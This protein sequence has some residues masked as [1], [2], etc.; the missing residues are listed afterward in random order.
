MPDTIILNIPLKTY[1]KKYLTNKYGEIHSVNKSSWLGRYLIVLLDKHY[2]KS[3]TPLTIDDYYPVS[4]SHSVFKEVGFDICTEKLKQLSDM[5]NKIFLNDLHSYIEVS[6]GSNLKFYNEVHDS[7]N[8]QNVLRAIKQFLK[9]HE[10][11]EDELSAD[12]LYRGYSRSKKKDKTI[13]VKNQQTLQ[14]L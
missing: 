11:Q 2:R 4:I 14:R 6:T 7:I 10:I 13:S 1:L 3:K 12:S 5:I 9:H 8:R